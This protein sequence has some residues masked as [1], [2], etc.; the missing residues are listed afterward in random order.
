MPIMGSLFLYNIKDLG[1]FG[2]HFDGNLAYWEDACF[3]RATPG[4]PVSDLLQSSIY[5]YNVTDLNQ[6]CHGS[7]ECYWV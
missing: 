7:L 1:P 6:I 5:R 4:N 2:L 3:T